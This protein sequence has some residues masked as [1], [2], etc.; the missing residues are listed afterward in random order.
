MRYTTN[1]PE[2]LP[3]CKSKQRIHFSVLKTVNVNIR[4]LFLLVFNSKHYIVE[5]KYLDD[6]NF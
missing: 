5:P 4:I 1:T 3:I 2:T 6:N